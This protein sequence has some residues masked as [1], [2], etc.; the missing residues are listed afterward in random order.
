MFK[1]NF[2]FE[3]KENDVSVDTSALSIVFYLPIYQHQFIAFLFAGQDH[4]ILQF[5]KTV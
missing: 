4:N 1:C 3:E 2:C 5:C